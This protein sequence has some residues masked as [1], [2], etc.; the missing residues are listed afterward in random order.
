MTQ[1]IEFWMEDTMVLVLVAMAVLGLISAIASFRNFKKNSFVSVI[2][3]TLSMFFWGLHLIWIFYIPP[4][5]I[6]YCC[7]SLNFWN[8]AVFILAPALITVFLLDGM[9]WFAKEGGKPALFRFFFAVTLTYFLYFIGQDWSL[10]TRAFFSLVWLFFLVEV[11]FPQKP[12]Q[13]A[14]FHLPRRI[15]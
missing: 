6:L 2:Y 7:I 3:F 15:L 11:E 10:S 1:N 14:T 5:S 8:W 13:Y 12:K 4:E 9:Y